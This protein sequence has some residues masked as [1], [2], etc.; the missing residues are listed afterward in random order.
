MPSNTVKEQARIPGPH[1]SHRWEA[2]AWTMVS[3]AGLLLLVFATAAAQ[4]P[5]GKTKSV[6]E[7]RGFFQQNCVRC[8]GVDG[9][10]H[11]AAGDKLG[12]LDFTKSA[13]DFKALAGP[14]SEREIRTMVKVIQ[15]GIFFGRVMP[16]WK[17]DLS[18]EDA[19][20]MVREILLKAER[21]KAIAPMPEAAKP[22]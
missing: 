8:H 14:G 12:G 5:A 1:H 22:S 11:T 7:L 18:P 6:N 21:G 9:S 2:Q 13:Q 16:S 15:K 4:P 20:V 19:D 3:S 10:A 17:E